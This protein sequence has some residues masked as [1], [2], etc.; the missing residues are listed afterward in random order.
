MPGPHLDN[1]TGVSTYKAHITQEALQCQQFNLWE[2]ELGRYR[3][4]H[5]ASE[6]Q[7]AEDIWERRGCG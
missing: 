1:D 6:D 4:V 7:V 2:E 3:Q 5:M